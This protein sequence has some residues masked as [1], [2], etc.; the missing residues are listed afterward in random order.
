MA[1]PPGELVG[2]TFA[3]PKSRTLACPRSV[4]KMLAGFMS[5]C[6]IPLAVGG[7][8]RVRNLHARSS[9][10]SVSIGVAGDA[11]LQVAPSRYSMAMNACPFSSPMS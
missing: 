6:T 1:P 8:E 2:A 10:S 11:M 5:R 4:T 7:V 9:I 3:N